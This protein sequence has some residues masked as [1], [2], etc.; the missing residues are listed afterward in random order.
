MQLDLQDL[1]KNL[2]QEVYDF[3]LFIKQKHHIP[4]SEKKLRIDKLNS[5]KVD[6]FTPLCRDDIYVR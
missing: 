2:Q 3:Y 6:S 5:L 4:K 1:P